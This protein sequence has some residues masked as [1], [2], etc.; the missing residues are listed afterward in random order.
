MELPDSFLDVFESS[1]FFCHEDADAVVE[2]SFFPEGEL[3]VESDLVVGD[4][5]GG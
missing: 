3:E 5:A 2:F 4:V 1:L